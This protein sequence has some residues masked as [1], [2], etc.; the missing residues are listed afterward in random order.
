MNILK[1][2]ILYVL[3]LL[4]NLYEKLHIINALN[5]IINN[6]FSFKQYSL[7]DSVKI[8]HSKHKFKR[9]TLFFLVFII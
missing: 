4:K 7:N 9:N 5:I 1:L 6:F 8:F 3:N 2:C